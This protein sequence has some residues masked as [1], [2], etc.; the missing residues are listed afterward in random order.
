MNDEVPSGLPASASGDLLGDVVHLIDAARQR[1]AVAVNAELTLLYWRVGRRIRDELLG[2]E[3][4]DYGAE[5]IKSLAAALTEAYGRG[6]SEKQL[7]HCL[8]AAETFSDEAA[9]RDLC[10][11]LTWT[12]I[13]T[14]HQSI[15]LAR[16]R[17]LQHGSDLTDP[18][19]DA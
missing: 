19:E 4:A 10:Q 8:R 17:L 18:T 2:G 16:Q 14:L 15:A 1:T 3:R 13:K 11:V 5:I 6:W 7:R 9:L 12:H